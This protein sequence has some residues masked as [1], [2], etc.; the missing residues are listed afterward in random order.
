MAL[1]LAVVFKNLAHLNGAGIAWPE[2]I[3][4]ATGR[5]EP[6]WLAARDAIARGT[7]VS[8]ALA[9]LLPPV[10]VAG[11]RAGETSGR[12]ETVLQALARRHEDEDRHR[13]ERRADLAY[14]VMLAH[15]SALLMMVPDLVGGRV[16]SAVLWAVAVLAPVYA[17][18]A[19]S[20]AVRRAAERAD[21]SKPPAFGGLFLT[22]AAVEDADARALY[23]LGWLH[24]AGV[25]I[26]E[27]IPLARRAGAG[28]RVA[29]DLVSAEAGVR[30]GR[31]LSGAWRKTP[32]AVASRLVN[33]EATG[34]LTAACLETARLMEEDAAARR[35]THA[36]MLKPIAILVIGVVVGARLISFYSGLYSNLPF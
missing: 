19:I 34:T 18:F 28:G 10:D 17:F 22:R 3:D 35:K 5:D 36:A 1:P 33:G 11:L 6:R 15:V 20:R 13:K 26:L 21:G 24:D 30:E 12:M 2:A 9:P 23:A 8:E 29:E 27:S 31:P 4:T 16:G 25:A 14:P 32:P 7:P